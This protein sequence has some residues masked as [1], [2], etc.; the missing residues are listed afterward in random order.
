MSGAAMK[1]APL[2]T[3]E[4]RKRVASGRELVRAVASDVLRLYPTL[5]ERDDVVALGH[6][7]LVEAARNFDPEM[8]VPFATFARFRIMG[9]ML[10]GVREEARFRRLRVAA[11]RAASVWLSEAHETVG[12]LAATDDGIRSEL[13]R[14]L[15]G[16]AAEIFSHIV[17]STD[18][19]E[20]GEDEL[21]VRESLVRARVVLGRAMSELG[22]EDRALL[23][24]VYLDGR[25]VKEAADH[26]QISYATYRRYL[27]GATARLG[28]KLRSLG[29][30]ESPLPVGA[31]AL[32]GER[33][34]A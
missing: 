4:Q 34:P 16:L 13:G 28:A 33:R 5:L 10:D 23:T 17:T 24:A 7:G 2:L 21:I 22:E 31:T 11:R 12:V 3:D 26:A 32:D 30:T 20:A 19:A 9:A 27:K 14:F 15:D 29:L 6:E 8:G 1:V 25:T 18:A